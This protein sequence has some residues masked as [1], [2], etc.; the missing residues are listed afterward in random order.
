MFIYQSKSI[1]RA[2]SCSFWCVPRSSGAPTPLRALYV[3]Q[4]NANFEQVIQPEEEV[5]LVQDFLN[6]PVSD[7]GVVPL[8]FDYLKGM[9]NLGP[10]TGKS[11][12]LPQVRYDQR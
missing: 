2:C 3:P 8:A 1:I 10:E 11:F 6:T 5:V 4:F 9:L 12:V 7:L